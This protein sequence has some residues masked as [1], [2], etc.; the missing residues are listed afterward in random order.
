MYLVRIETLLS[1]CIGRAI[2]GLKKKKESKSTTQ[3]DLPRFPSFE[4]DLSSTSST[5]KLD[6]LKRKPPNHSFI[7]SLHSIFFSLS[8]SQFPSAKTTRSSNQPTF[9]FLPSLLLVSF[10][11]FHS[12]CRSMEEVLRPGIV[13]IHSLRQL[14]VSG[15][16][17]E[18]TE[19]SPEVEV[20]QL[21]VLP[22]S[23]TRQRSSRSP[24]HQ[25]IFDYALIQVLI[26][27]LTPFPTRLLHPT[28][29]PS[30]LKHIIDES[31]LPSDSS[32]QRLSSNPNPNQSRCQTTLER[33]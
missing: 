12:L 3:A 21:D 1:R 31:P 8:S 29:S 30:Y 9:P 18:R 19:Q 6:I 28:Y 17:H 20:V 7:P 25:P 16:E 23:T 26:I 24:I 33:A 2:D 14:D 10:L 4:P 32:L 27:S 5:P 22:P 11:S 15:W 13:W